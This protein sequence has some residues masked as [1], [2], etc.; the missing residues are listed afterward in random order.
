MAIV[1]VVM[2]MQYGEMMEQSPSWDS[3]ED[4]GR[5]AGDYMLWLKGTNVVGLESTVH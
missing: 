4:K 2:V 1:V 3:S 5:E